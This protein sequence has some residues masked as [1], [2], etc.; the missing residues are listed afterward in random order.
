MGGRAYADNTGFLVN[1]PHRRSLAPDA[2]F[3]GDTRLSMRFA[4]GAPVSKSPLTLEGGLGMMRRCVR[5]TWATRED[6][7]LGL[8]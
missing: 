5:L 3:H 2:A 7:P 6:D 4:E 1:L 8:V